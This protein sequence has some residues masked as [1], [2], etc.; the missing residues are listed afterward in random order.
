MK[1]AIVL[2]DFYPDIAEGLL[3]S[4]RLAL[5]EAGMAKPSLVRV[6][7]LWK[8][9]SPCKRW[10]VQRLMCLWLWVALFAERHDILTLCRIFALAAFCVYSWILTLPSATAC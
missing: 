6:P 10:R 5:T 1:S 7:V 9:L 3:E 8:F 4:C 2:A